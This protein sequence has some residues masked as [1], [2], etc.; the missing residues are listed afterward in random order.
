MNEIHD[1]MLTAEKESSSS[2]ENGAI[3]N[4]K[5]TCASPPSNPIGDPLFKKRVK[6]RN[7]D[8]NVIIPDLRIKIK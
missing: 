6:L 2:K 8:L 1:Q 7:S 4:V 3:N 5:K